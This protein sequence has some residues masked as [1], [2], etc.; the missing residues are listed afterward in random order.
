MR[1]RRQGLVVDLD[2]LGGIARLR[3]G[4]GYDVGDAVADEAHAVG[5]E[6]GQED[7]VALRRTHVLGHQHGGEG[8]ELLGRGVGTGEHA[9]D[10]RGGL[11][12][13][14]V[15]PRDARVRVRRQDRHAVALARQIDVADVAPA[16][17]EEALV[18]DP[19]DG[20]P[21]AELVHSASSSRSR[22]IHS[23]SLIFRSCLRQWL[24]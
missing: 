6:Q 16:A 13:R 7:A 17:G 18:L 21:D 11:R 12:P 10:A 9:Y 4:L 14:D 24:T 22:Q 8:A 15:H 19:P 2:Q 20:L 3:R 5:D 23:C 1:H